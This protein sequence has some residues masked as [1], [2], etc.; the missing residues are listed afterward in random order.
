MR[1]W[2]AEIRRRAAEER[3]QERETR[4][5]HKELERRLKERARLSE[6]EQ[7][8]LE[9]EAHQNA[10]ELLLSVQKEQSEPIE[11]RKLASSLPPHRPVRSGQREFSLILRKG[12]SSTE[13][14]DISDTDSLEKAHSLD[15]R[16]HE[17]ELVAYET[18]KLE[19]EHL[20]LLAI[21][22]LAGEPGAYSEA[23]SE[24]SILNEITHIGSSIH[25]TVRSP[26]LIECVLTVNGRE[27]I[28]DQT[29]SLT[30]SKKLSVKAMPKARFHEIY[31]DYV[32][33][34]VL[35]LGR[36]VM[37]LLPVD[38]VLVTAS[39]RGLDAKTGQ[40]AQ[41]PVLSVAM[42]RGILEGLDFERLDPSD[43]MENFVHRG[44]VK[45]SRKGAEFNIIVPL[46]P[47]DLAPAQPERMNL[48]GL[49][50]RVREMR[51]EISSELTRAPLD[52]NP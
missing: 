15:E 11:W 40:S 22:V 21:R 45:A 1:S 44:D 26:K 36:E 25:F 24:F 41:L 12:A 7:A 48:T 5:R 52:D 28:P 33:G 3:R 20:R 9:V 4:Q 2:N 43:S 6:L 8:S 27:V 17:A 35:R 46:T 23:I 50:M 37:A 16:E 14:A 47:A 49:L 18:E 13:N 42:T 31:Q 29:K 32:C 38:E 30:A 39:V 34:C 19:C 10:L 51:A